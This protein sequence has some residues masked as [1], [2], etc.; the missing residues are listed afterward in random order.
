MNKRIGLTAAIGLMASVAS[1]HGAVACTSI[2]TVQDLLNSNSAGGC[3]IGD[4]LFSA[5]SYVPT[6]G[7]APAASAVDAVLVANATTLTFGWDIGTPGSP[8]AGNF[9]FSFTATTIGSS[10]CPQTICPI[11]DTESAM[12]PVMPPGPSEPEAFAIIHSAGPSPSF[13]TI[14]R[15]PAIRMSPHFP[16]S[17]RLSARTFQPD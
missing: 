13:L 6:S 11:T 2:V 1:L 3:T 7:T 16:A 8:I 9:I 4:K 12:S 15:L 10:T 5:F 17:H 14:C